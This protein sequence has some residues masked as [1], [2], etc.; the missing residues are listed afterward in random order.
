M[1]SDTFKQRSAYLAY[2]A[3]SSN[4]L[5][6]IA[7]TV[8]QEYER[9]TIN[10]LN[11][12]P[13]FFSNKPNTNSSVTT[14]DDVQ[15]PVGFANTKLA[16]YDRIPKRNEPATLADVNTSLYDHFPTGT[17]DSNN[18]PIFVNRYVY[19]GQAYHQH[20]RSS[21]RL[22][23]DK[24]FKDILVI[25][26]LEDIPNIPDIIDKIQKPI[27]LTAYRV[28]GNKRK[29]GSQ[30]DVPNATSLYWQGNA[31]T[32]L[33][34]IKLPDITSK[35]NGIQCM[36][37]TPTGVSPANSDTFFVYHEASWGYSAIDGNDLNG[38]ILTDNI[39]IQHNA[40]YPGL[41]IRL[42]KVSEVFD[43]YDSDTK[44]TGYLTITNRDQYTM[45]PVTDSKLPAD[46]EVFIFLPV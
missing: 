38:D 35:L 45:L 39:G 4:L 20:H 5:S 34:N 15:W 37:C 14:C 36:L 6:A 19:L 12:L 32:E 25:S 18:V 41:A 26:G 16:Y 43:N 31:D 7:G 42:G 10:V 9:V 30:Y 27:I 33:I 1:S 11:T 13:L 3:G 23:Y 40:G 8:P 29:T 44:L 28:G 2:N 24:E 46:F 17:V 21:R 22:Y